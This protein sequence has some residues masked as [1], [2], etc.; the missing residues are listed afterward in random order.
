MNQPVTWWLKTTATTQ[1]SA[2]ANDLPIF[3]RVGIDRDEEEIH[4]RHGEGEGERLV[5]VLGIE[6]VELWTGRVDKHADAARTRRVAGTLDDE[7][8]DEHEHDADDG[9]HDQL[10]DHQWET[11]EPSRGGGGQFEPGV[12]GAY[13]QD[14]IGGEEGMAVE[15]LYEGSNVDQLVEAVQLERLVHDVG[16]E[17]PETENERDQ[18]PLSSCGMRARE[19]PCARGEEERKSAEEER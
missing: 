13:R 10:I 6:S 19:A 11:G 2:S 9:E 4:H 18:D 7:E 5:G 12:V 15:Q 1:P 16:G 3:G 8:D 14:G 17:E